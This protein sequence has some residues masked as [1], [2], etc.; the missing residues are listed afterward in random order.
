MAYN[1]LVLGGAG[2]LGSN[3]VTTLV[4]NG[5]KV[6]VVD[7][8]LPGTGGNIENLPANENLLFL[9]NEI[10]GIHNLKEIVDANDYIIDAM[11]WTSHLSAIK[12][13]L[14][15]LK[16]NV[17]SHLYLINVLSDNHKVIYLSSSG[18][19]GSTE[20]SE[21]D[22]NTPFNP[23]DVQGI[24][25]LSAEYHY[26]IYSR[27]KGFSVIS[28][29]I[30]NCFGKNQKTQGE[31]IGLVGSFIRESLSAKTIEIYGETRK[32]SLLY[33]EDLS[34]II[35]QIIKLDIFKGFQ[36]M[37]INGTT[38]FIKDIAREIINLV[39]QGNLIIKN[40]PEHI[41]RMDFG[42]V[43]LNDNLFRSIYGNYK[44]TEISVALNNTIK[45]F[46]SKL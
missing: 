38:F 21:I 19:Y 2:F 43:P 27:I 35:T 20:K 7:G 13:P 4:S 42:G 12:D 10:K 8:M 40:I 30:P 25:K 45:Y 36:A 9:N 18:L 34:K 31:D 44:V 17:E 39:G 26:R 46:K 32:R 29:R 24:H 1:I 14:Y 22:E 11:A 37:N 33:S 41:K 5:N 15:D 16:L 23:L 3:I 6:T 28:L